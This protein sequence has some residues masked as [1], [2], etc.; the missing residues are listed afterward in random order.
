MAFDDVARLVHVLTSLVRVHCVDAASVGQEIAAL[1][2]V[3]VS[4]A[5][6]DL[7]MC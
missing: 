2:L 7:F 1:H 4:T 3:D 5:L 6:L